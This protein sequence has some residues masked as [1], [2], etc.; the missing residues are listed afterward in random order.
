MTYLHKQINYRRSNLGD[1]LLSHMIQQQ[2]ADD[3]A[4]DE[5]IVSIAILLLNAGH[6]ATVHQLGNSIV[7]VIRHPP[8]NKNWYDNPDITTN[9]VSECLRHDAPLHL[10]TRFAQVPLQLS[11]DVHIEAGTE[12]ALLLGAANHCPMQFSS[13]ELF[14]PER[15]SNQYVSLGAGIHFCV[16]APL[17]KLE[18]QIA[19]SSLFS[20]L[21]NLRL[22]EPPTY[23][24]SYHFHG[25]EALN[26]SWDT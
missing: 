18:L 12:I 22:T 13:P 26:V 25:L 14:N 3:G 1:D 17:A 5:E 20:R 7:N 24:N 2:K 10:F 21:P 4:S 23:R 19:L 16:G 9:V 15:E 8:K 6:E 11:A